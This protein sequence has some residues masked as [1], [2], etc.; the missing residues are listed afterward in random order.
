MTAPPAARCIHELLVVLD[1]RLLVERHLGRLREQREERLC[2]AAAEHADAAVV[3]DGQN[4]SRAWPLPQGQVGRC[5]VHA[6]SE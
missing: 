4:H 5:E 3:R 2:A 1:R 6:E